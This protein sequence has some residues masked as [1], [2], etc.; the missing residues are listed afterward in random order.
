MI[1]ATLLSQLIINILTI[2]LLVLLITLTVSA[3][4]CVSLWE[5]IANKLTIVST[6]SFW[7]NLIKKAPMELFTKNKKSKE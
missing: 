2:I 3:I 1:F 5:E 4:K 6:I 7:V